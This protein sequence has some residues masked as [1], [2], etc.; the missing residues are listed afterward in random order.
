MTTGGIIWVITTC[1]LALAFV[2]TWLALCINWILETMH[3]QVMEIL[4]ERNGEAR[5]IDL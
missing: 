5:Q 4:R 1:A 2:M 3:R